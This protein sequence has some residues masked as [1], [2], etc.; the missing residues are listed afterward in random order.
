MARAYISRAWQAYSEPVVQQLWERFTYQPLTGE[1]YNRYPETP[2]SFNTPAGVTNGKGYKRVYWLGKYWQAHRLV[3][4]WV[5]GEPICGSYHVHHING[6]K[7]DNRF[8][9]LSVL[10]PEVHRTMHR[11]K[12]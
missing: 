7:A 1:L 2:Y 6:N 5:T 10:P 4:M 8:C 12:V 9:N 3:W 11:E